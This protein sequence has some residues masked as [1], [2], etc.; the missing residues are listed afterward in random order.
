MQYKKHVSIL[1]T[2]YKILHK[3]YKEEPYFGR[4]NCDGYCDSTDKVIVV[5]N[6]NTFS[7]WENEREEYCKKV[8]KEILRHEII[9]AFLNESGLSSSSLIYEKGWAKNEEMVDFFA[10]QFTK[11]A[12]AFYELN[13]D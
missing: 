6:M 13:I 3:D 9:H 1:G 11:I 2:D 4:N 7:G 8:E 12:K 5:G 10:I